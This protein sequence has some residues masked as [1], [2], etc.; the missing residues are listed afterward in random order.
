MTQQSV[1]VSPSLAP[2]PHKSLLSRITNL[3]E[4]TVSRF[5]NQSYRGAAANT[6]R[7]AAWR[8]ACPPKQHDRMQHVIE[9]GRMPCVAA[10][11]RAHERCKIE[12]D[13][14]VR[15]F[16][17]ELFQRVRVLWKSCN[18]QVNRYEAQQSENTR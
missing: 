15:R 2:F 11:L 18:V 13:D 5:A 6:E 9:I 7:T 16:C 4:C 10:E 8:A 12:F 17:C 1:C 14:R 3:A